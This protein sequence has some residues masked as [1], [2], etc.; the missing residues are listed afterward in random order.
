MFAIIE[1]NTP[2][3]RLV[4]GSLDGSEL[5]VL[6]SAGR[7]SG[8]SIIDESQF[9]VVESIHDPAIFFKILKID[10]SGSEMIC[11]TL[12]VSRDYMNN[13]L[14]QNSGESGRILFFAGKFNPSATGVAVNK[15]FLTVFEN[16]KFRVLSGDTFA[17]ISKLTD[18]SKELFLG[19]SYKIYQENRH[20]GDASEPLLD[21][22]ALISIQDGT[23]QAE[24]VP[25]PGVSNE[26]LFSVTSEPGADF[27]FI[28]SYNF[29]SS[30]RREKIF[31]FQLSSMAEFITIELPSE[32]EFGNA[33]AEIMSDG[34]VKIRIPS[35]E[36]VRTSDHEILTISE[37]LNGKLRNLPTISLIAAKSTN[38]NTCRG[39]AASFALDVERRG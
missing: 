11:T 26:N 28:K 9:L 2:S 4:V 3:D 7:L 27:G 18:V 25:V 16:A 12:V 30:G 5:H 23:V 6:E 29:T 31:Q 38:T 1:N 36:K 21:R 13:P 32:R 37:Y 20:S 34:K 35:I 19:V 10:L 17:G 39:Q 14:Y 15:H 33:F 24:W 8:V 22:L